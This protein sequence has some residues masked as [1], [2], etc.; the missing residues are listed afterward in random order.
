MSVTR[1]TPCRNITLADV[2]RAA[3]LSR[4][5][6]SYALRRDPK[7]PAPTAA[8]V[9]QLAMDLGYRPNLRIKSLMSAIRQRHASPRREPLAFVWL[10]TPRQITK[11]APH[12]LY[13]SEAIRAGARRRAEE[14]G[15]TIDEFWLDDGDMRPE[16]LNQILRARGITGC[17]LNTAAS[18]EPVA[19]DWDWAPFA[20]TIIGH[21]QFSPPLHRAAHH[22][23]LGM[24][25][26]LQR[27]QQEGWRRPAA[28]LSRSVQNRIRQM[29]VGA[30]LANHPA[31][32]L[33]PSLWRF[34]LPE[35][36]SALPSWPEDLEPDALI[37]QWQVDRPTVDLL[38]AKFPSLRR[39]VTLDWYAYGVLP[40]IDPLYHDV[41]AK[42]VD[43]VVEQ[44]H[45][46]AL[47]LPVHPANLLIE[48]V[49]RDQPIPSSPKT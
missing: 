26:A 8:R 41:A 10:R 12:L 40:G 49:W 45:H 35:E 13:F 39:I 46:N 21:T 29:Q 19:L 16:R 33:A 18:N 23:Y 17:V 38:H 15:C 34:S 20:A 2:A 7:I 43:M 48:G 6:V 44:L 5:T 37:I 47:G 27:L 9:Q 4:A 3:G 24:C 31:P 22:H 32:A 25:T 11:L 42:A 14:L 1:P 28:L 30:F 36:F